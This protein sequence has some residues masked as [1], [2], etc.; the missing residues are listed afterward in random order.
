MVEQE[1]MQQI[2]EGGADNKEIIEDATVYE[3]GQ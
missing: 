2:V 3:S 1:N